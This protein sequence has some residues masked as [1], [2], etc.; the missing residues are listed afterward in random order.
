MLTCD[1]TDLGNPEANYYTFYKGSHAFTTTDRSYIKRFI[2]LFD[3]GM[4]SC[5]AMNRNQKLVSDM[6]EGS[7]LT[8][9]GDLY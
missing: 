4:Y 8:V 3:E 9:K 6:S 1:V 7:S 2:E 5:T